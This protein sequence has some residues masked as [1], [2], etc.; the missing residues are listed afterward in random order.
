MCPITCPGLASPSQTN[1]SIGAHANGTGGIDA[2]QGS[3]ELSS[4]A[5]GVVLVNGIDVLSWIGAVESRLGVARPE[6]QSTGAPHVSSSTSST[7]FVGRDGDNL[8]IRAGD[9]GAV[10]LNG[11]DVGARIDHLEAALAARHGASPPEHAVPDPYSSECTPCA[12]S[13]Q[14]TAAFVGG[15]GA[16]FSV[17]VGRVGPNLILNSTLAGEVFVNRVSILRRIARLAGVPTW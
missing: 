9:G 14:D 1:G 4:A 17:F 11:I 13:S 2:V 7:G 3:L 15:R 16:A 8:V 10:Y 5:G 12:L 6:P